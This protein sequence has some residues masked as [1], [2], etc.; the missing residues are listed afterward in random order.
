MFS[1]KLD[2]LFKIQV[3]SYL[4][5]TLYDS[6]D[7]QLKNKI[8]IQSNIHSHNARNND[9]FS[10]KRFNRSKSQCYILYRGLKIYNSKPLLLYNSKSHR[11][12]RNELKYFI[13]T[14][15]NSDLLLSF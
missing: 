11:D 2:A 13:V 15:I 3:C 1:L 14:N 7:D 4:Y 9:Q 8:I 12:F 6:Y 5:R 10:N